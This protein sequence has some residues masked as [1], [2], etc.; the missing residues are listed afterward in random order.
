MRRESR[1]EAR[2]FLVHVEQDLCF[3]PR[4]VPD[5]N[6]VDRTIPVLDVFDRSRADE[7]VV[8]LRRAQI[9]LK[10]TSQ[11]PTGARIIT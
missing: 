11:S 9:G 4:M 2:E 6:L 7:E 10:F 3:R 5:T 8:G 1:L